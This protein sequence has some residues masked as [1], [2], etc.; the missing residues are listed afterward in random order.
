MSKK[1]IIEYDLL[2]FVLV[3][4]VVIGHCAYYKIDTIYGG[5]NYFSNNNYP[6]IK[7][8]L[9]GIVSFI[10]TFHMPLFFALSGA[11]F[12]HTVNKTNNISIL[13][14]NKFKRLIIPFFAVALL[15]SIPLKYFSNYYINSSNLL[16][17]IIVGQLFIQGN[18]YLWFLPTLFFI[19]IIIYL[20]ERTKLS[21][22]TKII[23]YLGLNLLKDLIPIVLIAQ[24]VKYLIYFYIGFLFEKYKNKIIDYIYNHQAKIILIIYMIIFYIIINILNFIIHKYYFNIIFKI[25]IS[26]LK[27]ISIALAL[28][29]ILTF[30]HEISKKLKIKNN[31][32]IN[33]IN[34]YSFGIY[35]F[36]DPLNYLILFIFANILGINYFYTETGS[37]VIFCSRFILTL[38]ISILITFILDKLRN[39]KKNIY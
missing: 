14:R 21:V 22:K 10:Y 29:L 6:A 19:F 9:D 30:V 13:I 16:K 32:F 39:L 11:L 23:I 31:K 26:F 3:L 28:L 12:V 24:I 17:D 33:L 15:Y 1:R 5:I 2:R 20:L 37:L 4:L 34:K 35:L 38:S 8:L 27:A 18:N 7:Y 36:S 25:V